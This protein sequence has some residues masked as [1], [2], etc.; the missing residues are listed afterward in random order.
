MLDTYLSSVSNK[1][2]DIMKVL[3]MFSTI[4]IPLTFIAGVYGM[5]FEY[6]P[7]LN[8]KYGYIGFWVISLVVTG[9][10]VRFFKNKKWL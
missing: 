7:E 8:W 3:T 6:I 9:F 2:N 5:N 4:F 10:M 1:T